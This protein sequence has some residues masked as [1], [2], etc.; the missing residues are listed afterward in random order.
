MSLTKYDIIKATLE[1]GG[2]ALIVYVS[3][4]F[5]VTTFQ[6]LPWIYTG[7]K[8]YSKFSSTYTSIKP[9]FIWTFNKIG[10]KKEEDIE[11]VDIKK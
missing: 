1:I 2:T 10:M 8:I 3:P 9:V 7:W 5:V 6:Y 11:M 4:P